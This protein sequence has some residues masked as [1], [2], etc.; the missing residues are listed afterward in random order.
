MVV[1]ALVERVKSFLLRVTNAPIFVALMGDLILHRAISAAYEVFVGSADTYVRD[2]EGTDAS[3]P[4][5][6]VTHYFKLYPLY[7]YGRIGY[8]TEGF[9]G[10][11]DFYNVFSSRRV[12]R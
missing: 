8:R 10:F 5:D 2:L 7:V 11:N 4:R 12:T 1:E 6:H 3:P 9:I